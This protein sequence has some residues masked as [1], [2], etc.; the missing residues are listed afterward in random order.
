MFTTKA[1]YAGSAAYATTTA[2]CAAWV[3]F[4]LPAQ[5]GKVA[6]L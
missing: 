1:L 3:C 4:A 5:H 2:F 6:P